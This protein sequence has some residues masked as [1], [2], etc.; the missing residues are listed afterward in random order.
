MYIQAFSLRLKK[1]INSLLV[2]VLI[3]LSNCCNAQLITTIA[4]TGVQGYNGDNIPANA[5][6]LNR[7]QGLAVDAYGNIYFVDLNNCRIRKIT[8]ATGIITTIA[9]TGTAGYNGDN[10]PAATATLNYP[11]AVTLDVN[12]D[13]YFTDRGNQRI[14][15][16]N[17]S[18]GIITTVAGNGT[19]GYNGDGIAA[20][21]AQLNFPND[22][23]FDAS[24]NL[25]IADWFNHRVRKVNKATGL[26]STIAGTGSAGYNGDGI[27]ATTAQIDGPCGIIFDIYGN[28]YFAE[29]FNGQRIRKIT[30]STGL[31]S[32]IAGTGTAGYNGDGIPATTAQLQGPAYIRFDG[33]GNLYIGDGQNSRVRKV[34]KVTG[35]ISTIAGTGT[36]GYNGDGIAATTAQLCAPYDI[37]F[38]K[39]NCN[40]YIGD[41]NNDR[42]RKITGGFGDCPVAVAPGNLTSCQVLP[43]VTIN[44]SNFNA[45]VP[46]FDTAGKIAAMINA[47]G[48]TL[49]QVSTSIYTKNGACREDP[50]KRLYLNRNVTVTPQ[51]QPA[52]GNVSVRFYILKSELDS[53]KTAMNSQNQPSGVATI[54]DVDV[55]KNNSTCQAIGGLVASSLTSTTENYNADYY[56]QVNVT[57]FSSFYFANKALPEILPVKLKSFTGK[58][59]GTVNQLKWEADCF[60]AVVFNVE[61]STDGIHFST[62][63]NIHAQKTD[64]NKPFFFT[65]K[66][67]LP[68]NNFYR[69]QILEANGKVSYSAIIL[70]NGNSP[71]NIRLLNN[72]VVK[73]VLNIELLSE[74]VSKAE[75]ICTDATGRM[76]MQK[77]LPVYT[78]NNQF[79]ID[80]KHI[81]KGIY[82]LYTIAKTGRS[83]IIK[84][85]K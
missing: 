27:V 50:S 49:G 58:Q 45:W 31:I 24:G 12:G 57:S 38:D 54:N 1:I 37:Y 20:T 10:I 40:V 83:N 66:N 65:D 56:L 28:I 75:L 71:L 4:G 2:F 51:N 34:D 7:P 8:I 47:N 17:I 44:A 33:A 5:A 19:G 82:W 70:L 29:Y 72:P 13:I 64:C 84:F 21:A 35:L 23:S 69:L 77:V 76:I 18:T 63:E 22:V 59:F 53:L 14:R 78:G 11:S 46:V 6:Q 67:I 43:T 48:N 68:G 85:V 62:I 42:I 80:T 36:A 79:S 39:L 9:G 55:F 60:D 73:D 41:C 32:T 25:F 74:T 52:S 30:M 81:S 61:R 26:I 15:K 16:I 3:I